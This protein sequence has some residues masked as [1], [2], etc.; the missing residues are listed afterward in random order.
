[1]LFYNTERVLGEAKQ[2]LSVNGVCGLTSSLIKHTDSFHSYVYGLFFF[3]IIF[4]RSLLNLL[5]LLLLYWGFPGGSVVKTLPANAGETGSISDPGRSA[6]TAEQ[7]SP[8]AT[9]IETT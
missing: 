2:Q 8:G 9:T 1:M 7:L 6:R 4:L 5:Q 3:W